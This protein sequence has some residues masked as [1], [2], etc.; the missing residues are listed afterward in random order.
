MNDD[1][2]DIYTTVSLVND[3]VDGEF[4]EINLYNRNFLPF[5]EIRF[6]TNNAGS[7]FDVIDTEFEV[8]SE[9]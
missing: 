8:H 4:S 1:S 7:E 5:F 6:N 2:K 9:H 3:V